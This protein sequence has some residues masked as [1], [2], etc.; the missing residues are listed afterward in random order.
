MARALSEHRAKIAMMSIFMLSVVLDPTGENVS[1][2]GGVKTV[3]GLA[4]WLVG[5]SL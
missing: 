5:Y 4:G 1:M 2:H 3:L